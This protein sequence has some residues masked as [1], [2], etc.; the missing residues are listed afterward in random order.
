MI[1]NYLLGIK[2]K[3]L[4]YETDCI[5]LLE[6]LIENSFVYKKFFLC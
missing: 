4:F 5:M 3:K 2:I 1:K 6:N